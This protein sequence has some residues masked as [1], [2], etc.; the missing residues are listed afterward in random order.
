M[1]ATGHLPILMLNLQM[2]ML[3]RALLLEEQGLVQFGKQP[4]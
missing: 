4:L 2:F 1:L 3:H